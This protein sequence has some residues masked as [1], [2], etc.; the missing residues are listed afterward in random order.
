MTPDI[1]QL[2]IILNTTAIE[3]Y[4]K[5]LSDERIQLDRVLVDK[6]WEEEEKEEYINS[7]SLMTDDELFRF[8]KAQMD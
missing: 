6:P 5:K 8:Q 2:E 7:T 1:S 3:D 4:I